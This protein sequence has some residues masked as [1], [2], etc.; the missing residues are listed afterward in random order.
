MVVFSMQHVADVASEVAE[1]GHCSHRDQNEPPLPSVECTQA[2]CGVGQCCA[3][4]LFPALVV[5]P[6]LTTKDASPDL[7]SNL[8]TYQRVL[9]L[10]HPPRNAMFH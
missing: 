1:C 9:A 3:A 4:V 2:E 6:I 5:S 10:E 8:Y 7:W